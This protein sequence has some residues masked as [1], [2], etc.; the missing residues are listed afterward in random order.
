MKALPWMRLV[1]LVQIVMAGI[2]ELEAHERRLA[3][4]IAQRLYREHRLSAR[5]RQHL[6]RLA[7][8]AGRGAARRSMPGGRR[9]D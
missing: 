3:R 4:D 9:R 8:K 7:T 5:D 6:V 1:W 2:Q